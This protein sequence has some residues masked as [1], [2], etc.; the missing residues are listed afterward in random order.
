[1]I[2]LITWPMIRRR[3]GYRVLRDIE[4]RLVC[5]RCGHKPQT[6]ELYR[7]QTHGKEGSPST[8]TMRI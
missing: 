5:R 8:E 3:A 7:V 6:V 4:E 1:V 2:T